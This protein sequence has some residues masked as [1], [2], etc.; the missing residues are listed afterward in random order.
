MV[1]LMS[2]YIRI[3]RPGAT[4]F[5]T[6]N[7]AE[8]GS[9]VLVDNI[10]VL[11]EAVMATRAE[12][13]F[14][15]D[16]AVV[17]PDHLHMVWTLPEGDDAYSVRWGA[18]KSRFTMGLRRAGVGMPTGLREVRS[19]RYAG[20]K[21]GLR[22]DKRESAVWQRRFWEHHI[23][24]AADYRAHVEYCWMNPVKHGYVERPEDWAFSSYRRDVRVWG[25]G[26]PEDG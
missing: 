17:M 14:K 20:L 16:A 10:E 19:G 7:L 18:I 6:V 24:D 22:E 9:P 5:F 25:M 15:I 23:R 2:N 21:P 1:H 12:R 4:I 13:P 8:R 3:R 11:R 26:A